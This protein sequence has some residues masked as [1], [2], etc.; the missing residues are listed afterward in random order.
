MNR[1]K[2]TIEIRSKLHFS[3]IS[4]DE[5]S[6]NLVH[7]SKVKMLIMQKIYMSKEINI[8]LIIFYVFILKYDEVSVFRCTQG[9]FLC[10]ITS[11]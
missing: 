7:I 1:S 6:I 9:K 10:L 3:Q 8:L 4:H 2:F 5:T 11:F